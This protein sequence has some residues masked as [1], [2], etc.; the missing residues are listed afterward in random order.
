MWVGVEVPLLKKRVFKPPFTAGCLPALRALGAG[1]GCPFPEAAAAQE[2]AESADRS[3]ETKA[4][5]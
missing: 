4:Q 1:A 5:P 2:P 3:S